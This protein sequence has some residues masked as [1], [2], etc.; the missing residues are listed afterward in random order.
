MQ[1]RG[2]DSI[3]PQKQENNGRHC[4]ALTTHLE[5]TTTV[6]IMNH[7]N[8]TECFCLFVADVTPFGKI[9]L[10]DHNDLIVD[11]MLKIMRDEYKDH[12]RLLTQ[13]VKQLP[14]HNSQIVR[15]SF[16]CYLSGKSKESPIEFF[17]RVVIS[18]LETNLRLIGF[19]RDRTGS[20]ERAAADAQ[21]ACSWL[22]ITCAVGD[23]PAEGAVFLPKPSC[24]SKSSYDLL[25]CVTGHPGKAETSMEKKNQIIRKAQRHMRSLDNLK[26]LSIGCRNIINLLAYQIKPFPFYITEALEDCRLLEFLIDHRNVQQWLSNQVLVQ[27]IKD[28]VNG[29]IYISNRRMVT[30]DVTAYSM[31]VE[32]HKD[33]P[34][35]LRE[36]AS[37]I[38]SPGNFVVKI[39]DLG[40]AF[41]LPD[42]S[43][44]AKGK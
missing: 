21:E 17:K 38:L 35:S 23:V 6:M 1:S 15:Q 34:C 29:L 4:E 27:I 36:S 9:G 18:F 41:K 31:I 39:A 13:E 26:L 44:K 10:R 37:R 2:S 28:V 30:R 12:K 33:S 14:F 5:M 11:T 24:L 40:L 3:A 32:M 43:D 19:Q 7:N 16:N 20:T 8:F 42:G 25:M 22:E